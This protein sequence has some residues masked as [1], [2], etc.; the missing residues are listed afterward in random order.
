MKL[1]EVTSSK[2]AKKKTT[3]RL[4]D[5]KRLLAMPDRLCKYCQKPIPK[6]YGL[7]VKTYSIKEFCSREHYML[8][9][10]VVK[11]CLECGIEFENYKSSKDKYCEACSSKKATDLMCKKKCANPTCTNLIHHK[12]IFRFGA[13]R[14][15]CLQCF[16]DF[17]GDKL[18]RCKKCNNPLVSLNGS[19]KDYESHST[20]QNCEKTIF[21]YKKLEELS[22]RTYINYKEHLIHDTGSTNTES[23]S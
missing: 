17:M 15:C 5:N 1:S 22:K 18:K 7:S 11:N 2:W 19:F 23:G 8:F 16:V 13:R 9:H 20:H 3:R 4:T 10:R 12:T 14:F 21:F 6:V